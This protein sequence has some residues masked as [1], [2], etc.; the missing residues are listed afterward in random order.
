MKLE[1]RLN[2]YR[3]EVQK[4]LKEQDGQKMER[5]IK[6]AVQACLLEEEKKR[7][8]YLEFLRIQCSFIRK[9]WWLL[10][11]VFLLAVWMG[12]TMLG[13]AEAVKK[14][15]GIAGTLFVT[16]MI[17]ELWK[18][19]EN[20]ATEVEDSCLYTLRQ[21]YSARILLFLAADTVILSSFCLSG[22]LMW[23]IAAKDVVIHFMLPM[24]VTGGI[25]FG[26]LCSRHFVQEGVAMIA[27]FLW[28]SVWSVLV[29][30]HNLY[31]LVDDTVWF[32]VL[33][34][35]ALY[36]GCSVCKT[37]WGNRKRWEVQVHGS[38]I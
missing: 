29:M 23:D 30:N 3:S 28:S 2:L 35:A 17:P 15:L 9:R 1:D 32:G 20:G 5:C 7:L 19:R 33:F 10:Q 22:I 6:S 8:S 12:L 18:N 31:Q 25:C 4:E 38:E 34:L 36:L 11:A 14:G 37:V 16:M 21:I 27:C 26:T 13:S 24:T